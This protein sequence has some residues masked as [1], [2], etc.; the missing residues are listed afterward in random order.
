MYT[1]LYAR[2]GIP[3]M[4]TASLYTRVYGHHCG[5]RRVDDSY[6]RR[7]EERSLWQEEKNLSPL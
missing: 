1:S 4:Y 2:V 3:A 6:S 7:V 5:V